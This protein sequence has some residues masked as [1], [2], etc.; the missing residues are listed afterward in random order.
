MITVIAEDTAKGEATGTP[1]AGF[2]PLTTPVNAA[3]GLPPM[4]ILGLPG[5]D[6]T[7]IKAAPET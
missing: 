1:V 2:A 6:I 4:I 3:G 5:W 7:P